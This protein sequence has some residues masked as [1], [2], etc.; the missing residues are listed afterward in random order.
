MAKVAPETEPPTA[1][2]W[3]ERPFKK[4]V[5]SSPPLGEYDITYV[6]RRKEVGEKFFTCKSGRKFAYFTDGALDPSCEGVSI[7]FCHH[8]CGQSKY[9]WLMKEPFKNIFQ[10]S[11]D[12][13]GFGH[14]SDAPTA[15]YWFDQLVP[16]MVELVDAVYDE[17][18]IP[19]EKKF[20]VVG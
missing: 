19:K 3:F 10:V 14:S 7:L 1:A 20:F 2:Q 12:R 11:V 5:P 4:P 8:S 13:F 18:K 16:E 6:K 9:M 17:Y 15:G